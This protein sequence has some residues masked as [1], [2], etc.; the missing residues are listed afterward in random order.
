MY[1]GGLPFMFQNIY[2]ADDTARRQARDAQRDADDLCDRVD[3]LALMV[4]AMWSLTAEKL[5]ISEEEFKARVEKIDLSD[6]KLDGKISPHIGECPNC[7]RQLSKR[8]RNCIYC[9]Y[10]LPDTFV[11]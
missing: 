4:M 2:P 6:G 7:K 3:R 5:G 11:A 8:N 10:K 1:Y 9:G